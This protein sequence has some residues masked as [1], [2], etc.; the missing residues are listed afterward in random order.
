MDARLHRTAI[1][2]TREV[3]GPD[4]MELV[5]AGVI[6]AVV[7]AI[8]AG[9][10]GRVRLMA[11]TLD[12]ITLVGAAQV[13][14]NIRAGVEESPLTVQVGLLLSASLQRLTSDP[15]RTGTPAVRTRSPN[16]ML[17]L[18]R[19]GGPGV[20]RGPRGRGCDG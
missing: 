7:V 16:K 10:G 8:A 3:R 6:V 17:C 19:K 9:F 14:E 5:A 15:G 4:A 1:G 12:A 18:L 13:N 11:Q 20:G 2:R